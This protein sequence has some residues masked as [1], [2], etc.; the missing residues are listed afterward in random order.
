MSR[1]AARQFLPIQPTRG[2]TVC[3]RSKTAIL[4][5]RSEAGHPFASVAPGV[6]PQDPRLCSVGAVVDTGRTD[7]H[8][9]PKPSRRSDHR[10]MVQTSPELSRW[11][12]VNGCSPTNR[13]PDE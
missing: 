11:S 12:E 8:L 10:R 5:A 6:A 7:S 2:G 1:V 9:N 13:S 3:R 4:A